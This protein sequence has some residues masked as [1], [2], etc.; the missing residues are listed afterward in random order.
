MQPQISNFQMLRTFDFKPAQYGV[1]NSAEVA[2][3]TEHFLIKDRSNIELQNLRD[4][5][6][7]FYS[8]KIDHDGNALELSDIMSGICGVIDSEKWNRGM[9]V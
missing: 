3:I 2:Q 7:M 8:R 4:F 6:V 9:E 1:L 5:V